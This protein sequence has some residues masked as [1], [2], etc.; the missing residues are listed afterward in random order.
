MNEVKKWASQLRESRQTPEYW[1]A[2]AKLE[3]AEGIRRI[4]GGMTQ[5]E[6]AEKLGKK[7]NAYVSRLLAG[8]YNFTIRRMNEIAK[9]LGAAVHVYVAK[10]DSIPE[11]GTVNTET[12]EVT[13]AGA[14][15]NT[16]LQ[17]SYARLSSV[18]YSDAIS[19]APD[20]GWAEGSPRTETMTL[21][22]FFDEQASAPPN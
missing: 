7:S 14:Y 1:T 21:L 3:F 18:V 20:V 16:L 11:W 2:L 19:E 6:L 10:K 17:V 4:M 15:E 13:L 9:S 8:E 5:A 22:D 12:I